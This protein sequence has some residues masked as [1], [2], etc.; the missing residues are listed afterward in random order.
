VGSSLSGAGGTGGAG[1]LGSSLTLTNTGTIQGGNG[2][3]NGA[4]ATG[5]VA[6]G[7]AGVQGA[8]LQIINGGAIAG[9]VSG[10]GSTLANA[11]TFT[12]GANSLQ[13]NQGWRFTGNVVGSSGTTNTL[14]LGGDTTDL[15]SNAA[16]TSVSTVFA[17]SQTG[18]L[19]Q[20]FTLFQ[21]TGAS[22]WALIGSTSAATPWTIS[23]G[24]LQ[25]GNGT[26]NGSI[27]GNVTDNATFAFDPASG[28]S[29][30]EAGVIAGSGAVQQIGAGTT[31]LSGVNT[32][33][34][35][36]TISAGTLQLTTT[37]AAGTGAVTVSTA[38]GD[39]AQG[40]NLDFAT[41]GN[42]ANSLTGDG[43]TTVAAGSAQATLTGNN[44]AYA[45]NWQIAGSAAVAP[46]STTSTTSLGA[47][48]VNIA[49]GGSLAA[50]TSGAFS[51]DNALTGSGTLSASNGGQ[52][53]SFGSGAGTAFAGTL[54]LS[55]DTFAL[56]GNN[57]TAL[58]RATLA[59][60]AGSGPRSATAI[61]P[62][63]PSPSMAERPSST[64]PRLRSSSPPASSPQAR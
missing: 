6:A 12:G 55:N 44:T 14:I 35:G 59:L 27:T 56:S 13:L 36:T 17:L 3:S 15:M 21:K 60:G 7:G 25:L 53:F 58:T 50:T 39:T 1:V 41:A 5:T 61:K 32:Y 34:G 16:G 19:F 4:S 46:S 23:A 29:M 43:V 45:G 40:L 30:T 52:A 37:S 47:G 42:F 8:N 20:G 9:G 49:S 64:G 63:A 57:T 10:D 38:A 26:T 62:S 48:T 24:T 18:T 33:T 2:G 11:I 22:T 51:F 54:S 28:T 31:V